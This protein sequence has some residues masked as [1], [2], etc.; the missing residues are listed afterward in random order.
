MEALMRKVFLTVICAT[1]AG[2][3][4]LASAR[5]ESAPVA[6]AA[7]VARVPHLSKTGF[8]AMAKLKKSKKFGRSVP[9]E[10]VKR[11]DSWYKQMRDP[12]QVEG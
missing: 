5:S 3:L 7:D 2:F 12:C 9:V 11:D 6:H 1:A 8:D 10:D 4:A